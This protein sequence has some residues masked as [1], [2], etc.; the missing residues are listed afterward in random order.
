M[1]LIAYDDLVA[2][3]W[4]NGGGITRELACYPPNAHF[5]DFLWRVSIADIKQ[6]GSF[7]VFPGIDRVIALLHGDGMQ[8]HFVDGVRHPLTIPLQPYRFAGEDTLDAC[9][10]DGECQDVNLMLRR[11]VTS[12]GMDVL[13]IAKRLPNDTDFR[14]LFSA[15]GHWEVKTASGIIYIIAPHQTLTT[16]AD[17][18]ALEVQPMNSDCALVSIHITL[19]E[20]SSDA[21]S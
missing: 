7:S 1:N 8:L 12:G 11:G 16:T 14:L 13:H 4:K 6:S 21:N 2:M 20:K 9:L 18:G 19:S 5:D 3:P 17:E 15:R 10:V